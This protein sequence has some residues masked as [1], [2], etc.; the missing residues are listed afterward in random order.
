MKVEA[1]IKFV[2]VSNLLSMNLVRCVTKSAASLWQ[3]ENYPE[4]GRND[5][6][7][8]LPIKRA[9]NQSDEIIIMF[10][11]VSTKK[12]NEFKRVHIIWYG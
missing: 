8:G 2:R 1:L 3:C 5:I 10:T 6:K 4:S 11:P 7:N 12:E 9:F